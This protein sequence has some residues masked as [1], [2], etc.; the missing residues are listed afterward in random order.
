V[1][2][3]ESNDEKSEC[4]WNDRRRYTLLCSATLASLVNG[5]IAVVISRYSG[6]AHWPAADA[7]V[8]EFRLTVP[9]QH[10]GPAKTKQGG[11]LRA[12]IARRLNTMVPQDLRT[13]ADDFEDAARDYGTQ[14]Q[15]SKLRH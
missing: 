9:T 6:C 5:E 3:E 14:Q 13:L 15:I 1:S 2:S 8:V 10:A 12:L 11:W 7:D 4:A